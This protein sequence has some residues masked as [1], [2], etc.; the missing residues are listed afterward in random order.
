MPGAQEEGGR[1]SGQRP[2]EEAVVPPQ[3]EG[4]EEEQHD[5]AVTEGGGTQEVEQP[6]APAQEESVQGAGESPAVPGEEDTPP[7]AEQLNDKLETGQHANQQEI[8]PIHGLP[9]ALGKRDPSQLPHMEG[10]RFK[11][12]T[13]SSTITSL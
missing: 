9:Q 7:D 12:P 10:N 4:E 13:V 6:A 8:V 3:E 5:A 1:S 11:L 2:T